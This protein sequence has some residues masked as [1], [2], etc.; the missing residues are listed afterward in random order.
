MKKI[1]LFCAVLLIAALLFGCGT[2]SLKTPGAGGSTQEAPITPSASAP[3][4]GTQDNPCSEIQFKVVYTNSTEP[5]LTWNKFFCDELEKR[6]GGRYKIDRYLEGQLGLG[7]EDA[8]TAISE[9]SIQILLGGEAVISSVADD[10]VGVSGIP[11]AFKSKEHCRDFWLYYRDEI[12]KRA[13]DKYNIVM[14]NHDTMELEGARCLTANK[15][16]YSLADMNGI[17]LRT[18]SNIVIVNAWKAILPD[19]TNIAL[20]ELYGALQTG[21]V[22]AQE[23]PI[24]FISSYSFNEVQKYLMLTRHYYPV[25]HYITNGTFWDSLNDADRELFTQVADEACDGY[26]RDTEDI[27]EKLIEDLKS[28][29]MNVIPASEMKLDEFREKAI[30]GLQKT[31]I[32]NQ[33][34]WDKIT[35]LGEKY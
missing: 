5:V 10:I 31:D 15:P 23:N 25:R 27:E 11:F 7:D 19:V 9:N 32:W 18:S 30:E 34:V 1:A 16:V 33:A 17:K 12:A 26:N 6:S 2:T 28:K 29:G 14:V 21:V 3:V 4:S 13:R 35:E 20:A 8:S 24:E 22:N